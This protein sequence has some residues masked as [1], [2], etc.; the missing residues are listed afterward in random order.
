[1]SR[2][3]SVRE[4]HSFWHRGYC[5]PTAPPLTSISGS[6]VT[7]LVSRTLQEKRMFLPFFFSSSVALFFGCFGTGDRRSCFGH[8]MYYRGR[9]LQKHKL[10]DKSSFFNATFV[11]FPDSRY[12]EVVLGKSSFL[13]LKVTEVRRPSHRLDDFLWDTRWV[14]RM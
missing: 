14:P 4:W 10:R 1:M 8:R 6:P 11:C 13:L 2:K 12:S 3:G 9:S 7:L 5:V